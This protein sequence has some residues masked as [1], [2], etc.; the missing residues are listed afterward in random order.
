MYNHKYFEL[1]GHKIHMDNILL[2]AIDKTCDEKGANVWWVYIDDRITSLMLT[3]K[4]RNQHFFIK[5][6]KNILP[7]IACELFFVLVHYHYSYGLRVCVCLWK[8]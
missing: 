7:E 8:G 3:Q 4:F 2:K 5:Q 1:T 6:P